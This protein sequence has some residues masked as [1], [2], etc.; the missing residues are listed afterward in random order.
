MFQFLPLAHQRSWKIIQQKCSVHFY[1]GMSV[2]A[3]LS[4]E[5]FPVV[6]G[7]GMEALASGRGAD[8]LRGRAWRGEGKPRASGMKSHVTLKKWNCVACGFD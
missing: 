2:T 5:A 3:E 8:V 1:F 6:L 7:Y 4:S